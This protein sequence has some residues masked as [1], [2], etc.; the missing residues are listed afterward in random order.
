MQSYQGIS[1]AELKQH[2]KTISSASSKHQVRLCKMKG[3][4]VVKVIPR[5]ALLTRLFY[6]LGSQKADGEFKQ[7][8]MTALR[9]PETDKSVKKQIIKNISR[10][11]IPCFTNKES[12]ELKERRGAVYNQSSS[13]IINPTSILLDQE[14]PRTAQES[15]TYF[16]NG[17]MDK[18]AVREHYRSNGLPGD[19]CY[20][21][22]P[23]DMDQDDLSKTVSCLDGNGIETSAGRLFREDPLTLV[24]DFTEMSPGQIASLNELFDKPPRFKGRE[25]GPNVSLACLVTK[26]MFKGGSE[27]PSDDTWRRL[28][29]LGQKP[30]PERDQ[31][32]QLDQSLINSLTTEQPL[33]EERF[34]DAPSEVLPPPS[35]DFYN[36]SGN[37]KGALM[38]EMQLSSE[39]RIHFK[40]GLL[41]KLHDQLEQPEVALELINAPTDDPVFFQTLA[42]IVREKGY[43]ANGQWYSVP[44]NLRL[45]FKQTSKTELQQRFKAFKR[46][47]SEW[48][49][50]CINSSN[51]DQIMANLTLD[52][53]HMIESDTLATMLKGRKRLMISDKLTEHQWIRLLNKLEGFQPKP[54]IMIAPQCKHPDDL[55]LSRFTLTSQPV[56]KLPEPKVVSKGKPTK[57]P[58]FSY[59][60]TSKTDPQTLLHSLTLT[61]MQDM[62]F[63]EKYTPLMEALKSGQPVHLSGLETNPKVARQLESLLSSP[64]YVLIGAKA[65]SLRKINL[66]CTIREDNKP[67]GLWQF[68]PGEK[69]PLK[70]EVSSAWLKS[71]GVEQKISIL[72]LKDFGMLLSKLNSITSGATEK[73]LKIPPK[74]SESLVKKVIVQLDRETRSD[75]AQ[76]PGDYHWQKALNDV[77]AKEYR[78]N[79]EVYSYIKTQIV[80]LYPGAIPEGSVDQHAIRNWLEKHPDPDLNNI[81]QSYWQLA[82]YCSPASLE[83]PIKLT[84]PS[85]LQL[86]QL[87]IIM[88]QC[89]SSQQQEKLSAL[90]GGSKELPPAF[91]PYNG[92]HYSRAYNALTVAGINGRLNKEEPVHHQARALADRIEHM[93]QPLSAFD[94]KAELLQYFDPSHLDQN[95]QDIAESFCDASGS[96]IRQQR[97]VLKLSEKLASN[98]MVMITGEAG[99]GKSYAAKAAASLYSGGKEPTVLSLS[100]ENTQEELFGH[101]ITRSKPVVI[102][103]D[104]LAFC[105]DKQ[106]AW[107]A[108]C[109][110]ANCSSW[111]N[112]LQ[113][114]LNDDAQK[115]LRRELSENDFFSIIETF[116]DKENAFIPG[117]I[118]EWA[119]LKEPP[120]LILDEAN[121]VEEGVLH[122]LLGLM[123]NPPVLSIFGQQIK[124][125]DRHRIILTG[126]P[127]SYD[128][129][130]IDRRLR[131]QMLP[132]FYRPISETV[133]AQSIFYPGLPTQWP[134][135]LR[136]YATATALE[137]YNH[138]KKAVP[139]HTFGPRDLNDIQARI[140]AYC[141]KSTPKET[142]LNAVIWQ[143][144]SDSLSG[145][146]RNNNRETRALKHWYQA[147]HEVDTTLIKKHR[148]KFNT[149]YKKV[150][151]CFQTDFFDFD[152]PSVRSLARTVWTDMDKAGGKKALIIEGEAGRGKDALLDRM[153]PE[154]LSAKGLSPHFK[155]IN[156]SPENW[157]EIKKL[158]SEAMEKGN[159]LVISELNTLPSRF[160]EG[161]FNEVLNG[162]SAPGFKLIAT[163]NPTAYSG[164]EEFSSAMQSRCTM[165]KIAQF[166]EPELTGLLKRRKQWDDS[167]CE[168]LVT[169]HSSLHKQLEEA[170]SPMKLPLT[171]LLDAAHHLHG[172]T[173]ERRDAAFDKEYR[174]A[175]TAL[176]IKGKTSR[177]QSD[178]ASSEREEREQTL[179]NMINSISHSPVSVVLGGNRT[180]PKY[181]ASESKL[182]LPDREDLTALASEAAGLMQPKQSDSYKQQL[183]TELEQIKEVKNSQK[184]DTK[185]LDALAEA[186]K[187]TETEAENSSWVMAAGSRMLQMIRFLSPLRAALMLLTLNF[188]IA[189]YILSR[190]PWTQIAKIML[191]MGTDKAIIFMAKMAL[192]TVTKILKHIPFG[193]AFNLLAKLPFTRMLSLLHYLPYK[194]L[195]EAASHFPIDKLIDTVSDSVNSLP[196]DK[197]TELFDSIP[198]DRLQTVMDCLSADKVNA[199][200]DILPINSLKKAT[201]QLSDK[202]LENMVAKLPFDKLSTLISKIPSERIMSAVEKV[203]PVSHDRLLKEL[204]AGLA[205][206]TSKITETIPNT[207]T[208][209][210]PFTGQS[211]LATE[212]PKIETNKRGSSPDI[213]EKQE[214]QEKLTTKQS[215]S[216][217]QTAPG[218]PETKTEEREKDTPKPVPA[219][220]QK[221]PAR[222]F[223][224]NPFKL[225]GVEKI[226]D[227]GSSFLFK[228]ISSKRLKK[229]ESFAGKL[230]SKFDISFGSSSR[231]IKS[232]DKPT[233]KPVN[234]T[235]EK[236][237]SL[238]TQELEKIPQ[239][240][241]MT[242]LRTSHASLQDQLIEKLSNRMLFICLNLR[243]DQS[244]RLN[245][246]LAD[247]HKKR[248]LSVTIPPEKKKAQLRLVDGKPVELEAKAV[249]DADYSRIRHWMNPLARKMAS[250]PLGLNTNR[251]LFI[252]FMQSTMNSDSRRLVTMDD[253]NTLTQ[254]LKN[255]IDVN[256]ATVKVELEQNMSDFLDLFL[257]EQSKKS[258]YRD[259]TG[260]TIY[261]LLDSAH[262][263]NSE[264][265]L[266][267]DAFA[268]M[269]HKCA[270]QKLSTPVSAILKWLPELY[271]HPEFGEWAEQT[272]NEFYAEMG[273]ISEKRIS[274]SGQQ[275]LDSKRATKIPYLEKM[276]NKR[277]IRE[278]FSSNN[279]GQAADIGRLS[280]RDDR[281]YPVNSGD[282]QLPTL[283]LAIS[284][285]EIATLFAETL[286]SKP[287][288]ACQIGSDITSF[289]KN[290]FAASL[291]EYRDKANWKLIL[292][293][294]VEFST[295]NSSLI[296]FNAISAALDPDRGEFAA[297]RS[298]SDVS[299]PIEPLKTKEAMGL[300]N[301]TFLGTDEL[302]ECV[303]SYLGALTPEMV[304][305]MIHGSRRFEPLQIPG[306]KNS[307][308]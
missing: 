137:L 296:P 240:E 151:K 104:Q 50:A 287:A 43:W 79:L 61:S 78:G 164:R 176:S 117:R 146:S 269:L 213:Q 201:D 297:A 147:H 113:L 47:K 26:N 123:E 248:M 236:I 274:L 183:L 193:Q 282:D 42:T 84:K 288:L 304:Y 189:M 64:P 106:K 251:K 221:Q 177:A 237:N 21:Q 185:G 252:W 122:P 167:F 224:F 161:L 278:G 281:F 217:P 186:E 70:P 44:E 308:S 180:Y 121:M 226:A 244:A 25:L 38:G 14:K 216:K 157:N 75:G 29:S 126:N 256:G 100:P 11:A 96:G 45:S 279:T 239:K 231:P 54:A 90:M 76:E 238:T 277:T 19:S 136:Q 1:Q 28:D 198:T 222:R 145:E 242:L 58:V 6:W 215:A 249:V 302:K 150:K 115:I 86:K 210:K 208:A 190:L 253:M 51:F 101:M 49:F 30:I 77:I 120:V 131:E 159:V 16:I 204:P 170:D 241:F 129:R 294:R 4:L 97:R 203:D 82:R 178:K 41:Y 92:S 179:C 299:S 2:L 196:L 303:E 171:K 243:T 212:P 267:R 295:D 72:R 275:R 214:K 40:K 66:S 12:K 135:P 225:P 132:Q 105:Q 206:I 95:F 88:A 209:E 33:D 62:T 108:L 15:G 31:K 228:T 130:V 261:R 301:A 306:L 124:L 257:E 265:Y 24:L 202:N 258:E 220:E 34:Y 163:I 55:N 63:E 194:F 67:L 35:H 52:G 5:Y 264:G 192:P 184:L 158:V 110:A 103:K 10:N 284:H 153:L 20:I 152:V 246:K 128:G 144:M 229:I 74:L 68:C 125:T 156:A 114:P 245:G 259:V 46:G 255:D 298:Q 227:T 250:T 91:V 266:S 197:F 143:S 83:V 199:L 80:R 289:I 111:N 166:T 263:L 7:A 260:L 27:N 89:A 3:H 8:I 181:H 37:W 195:Y 32:L 182:E 138:Y 87:T 219:Q 262:Q 60:I 71:I 207:D 175:L 99:T 22:K 300:P 162:D 271:D 118:L 116:D 292:P 56:F 140:H 286:K 39:G 112:A 160:L 142:E 119:K 272:T 165:A 235:V 139:G 141:G 154:C 149:Y 285:H 234:H 9:N 200:C 174:M 191:N 36:S 291:Y 127:E 107:K 168:W 230:V 293:T 85:K 276:L 69:A 233:E 48:P 57:K 94:V 13:A 211:G 270:T 23:A 307:R 133:L 169:K 93:P 268:R 65:V 283:I 102:R 17:E 148:D 254:L 205:S 188:Q 53:N 155:R 232:I 73:I 98:P 305:E 59:E 187:K 134:E 247:A 173:P 172:E 218:K 109:Q 81:Q 273:Q 18:L 280:R 223:G 290:Y